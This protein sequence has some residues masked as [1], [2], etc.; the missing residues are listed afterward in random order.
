MLLDFVKMHGTGNDFVV[1][2]DLDSS[3]ELS[4]E[5][6]AAVCRRRFGVGADGLIQVRRDAQGRFYMHYYNADGSLAEMCGNGIRCLAKYVADRGMAPG[7]RFVVGTLGGPRTV[8]VTRDSVGMVDTVTVDMGEPIFDPALVP[9]DAH[10]AP[11]DSLLVEVEGA[12]LEFFVLSM[13]NPHA[14]TFVEDVDSA[15]VATVGPLVEEHGLF[16]NKTNVE[17]AAVDPATETIR[18]RVWERGVGETLACGTGACA[19][20]VAASMKCL[21]GRRASVEL[22]GGTLAVEW[23]DDGHVWMTGPAREVFAGTIDV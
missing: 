16:P 4:S 3:V 18:L 11:V 2:E 21:V 23:A 14:V 13:G 19:A 1:M 8:E 10:E 20:T 7:E 22:P 17:F 12:A 6:V 15:P 9:V 5:Q